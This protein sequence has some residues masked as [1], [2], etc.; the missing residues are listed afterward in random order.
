V[1]V[2]IILALLFVIYKIIINI[3]TKI[4]EKNLKKTFGEFSIIK[5]TKN[6]FFDKKFYD[7]FISELVKISVLLVVLGLFALLFSPL[8]ITMKY[9]ENQE[10]KKVEN[11]TT[12]GMIVF[13]IL[14]D[15]YSLRGYAKFQQED[16]E[17]AI[18]DYDKAYR[19]GADVFNAMNFDNKIFIKY[20]LKDYKGALQDFD[21][22]I[23]NSDNEYE[24]DALL[25][26][27]AQFL[28]NIGKYTDALDLYTQ[29][30][31]KADSD[32]VFLLKDR[33]YLERAQIYQKLGQTDLAQADLNNSESLDSLDDVLDAI[34]KPTLILNEL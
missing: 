10:Y 32:S 15:W 30:L 23:K 27:K 1:N 2:L 18:K 31:S 25:W 13:P 19:L 16:Y 14:P 9:I 8:K 21:N 20:Y 24:K 5:I 33:L 26:D 7:L 12:A 6:K 17:G 29:L 4:F 22:E 28:Y 3:N 34:P 11:L